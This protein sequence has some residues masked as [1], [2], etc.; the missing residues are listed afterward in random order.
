M[1]DANELAV[2]C[3]VYF[4][5]EEDVCLLQR[6][7]FEVEV[8]ARFDVAPEASESEAPEWNRFAVEL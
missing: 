4:C 2:E 8:N 6:V 5:R 1:G 3:L 7:R